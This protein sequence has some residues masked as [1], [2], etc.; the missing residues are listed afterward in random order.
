VRDSITESLK[1]TKDTT[2]LKSMALINMN[3]EIEKKFEK[4]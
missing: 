4:F 2:K 1:R 3:D